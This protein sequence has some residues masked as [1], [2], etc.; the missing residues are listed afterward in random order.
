[1]CLMLPGLK[2]VNWTFL[3]VIVLPVLA[4]GWGLW[5]R[6]VGKFLASG[7]LKMQRSLQQPK[8]SPP[9]MEHELVVGWESLPR[10]GTQWSAVRKMQHIV[11]SPSQ[12]HVDSH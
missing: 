4:S 5:Q 10:P 9:K 6:G 3:S 12:Q 11:Y 7:S 2:Q 8:G 1:M